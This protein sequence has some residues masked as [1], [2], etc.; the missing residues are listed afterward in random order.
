MIKQ[1]LAIPKTKHRWSLDLVRTGQILAVIL[2]LTGP[3]LNLV[4][5]LYVA[6]VHVNISD[7]GDEP[8]VKPQYFEPS[9]K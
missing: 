2:I 5:L 3:G 9:V 1:V 4:C 6:Y 8:V 7:I